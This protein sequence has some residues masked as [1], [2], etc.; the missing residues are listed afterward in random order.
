MSKNCHVLMEK[1]IATTSI[2]G[3][4]LVAA[5][6]R[7]GKTLMVGYILRAYPGLERIKAIIGSGRLGNP[8]SA[9]VMLSAANTLVLG[10]SDYRRS[11][12]TGG[13]IIFDFS[14]EIDYLRYFFGEPKRVACFKDLRVRAGVSCDD[15][16]E[17]I[18]QFESGVLAGLHMDYI[19]ECGEYRHRRIVEIICEKGFIWYDFESLR[20]QSNEGDEEC[21]KYEDERND[22]FLKQLR[23]FVAACGGLNVSYVTGED[24]T[25]TVKIC[26]DLYRYDQETT[27]KA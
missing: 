8:V 13:G 9:R 14:H 21:I 2:D 22:L 17:I 6:K 16:A 27:K 24:A 23:T 5:A 25:K 10:R 19:Q 11:Y 12:E 20:V 1:P 18:M 4:Q 15:V 7:H 3:E 26:E